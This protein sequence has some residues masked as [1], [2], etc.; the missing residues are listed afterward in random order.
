MKLDA[1]TQRHANTWKGFVW[2]L[3]LS[4]VGCVVVLGLMALF[5]L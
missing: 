1:E 4:T 5:L 3:T 2:F